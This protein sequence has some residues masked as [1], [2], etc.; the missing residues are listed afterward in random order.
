MP[1]YVGVFGIALIQL[2]QAIPLLDVIY[3]VVLCQYH[4]NLLI[5][6]SPSCVCNHLLIFLLFVI[7]GTRL[8][9]LI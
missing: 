4:V 3:E 7:L 5:L 2:A 8:V 6:N 1:V 9:L